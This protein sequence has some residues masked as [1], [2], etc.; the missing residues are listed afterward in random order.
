VNWSDPDNGF[1]KAIA[2][3]AP[4]VVSDHVAMGLVVTVDLDG[5]ALWTAVA[6]D[7]VLVARATDD[8]VNCLFFQHVV[9]LKKREAP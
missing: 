5:P 7:P 2:K 4:D 9:S 1:L 6:P 3:Q 8:D